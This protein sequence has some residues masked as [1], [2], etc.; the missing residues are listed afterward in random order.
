MYVRDIAFDDDDV[1]KPTSEDESS[2]AFDHDYV[3]AKVGLYKG[4]GDG[5]VDGGW[6]ESECSVLECSNHATPYHPS[7]TPTS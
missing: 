2:S 6:C 4:G 5:F 7:Q 3:V 1:R